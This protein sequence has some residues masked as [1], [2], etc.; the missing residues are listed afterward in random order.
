MACARIIE[1]NYLV[2]SGD[3]DTILQFPCRLLG[4]R[5]NLI[6]AA[7][8]F[9]LLLSRSVK[10][11]RNTSHFLHIYWRLPFLKDSALHFGERF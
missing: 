4:S 2:V 11:S 7:K 1:Q 5:H 9:L 8:C 3:S 10:G 6:S